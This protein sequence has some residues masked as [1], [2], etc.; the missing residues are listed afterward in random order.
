MNKNFLHR[1]K[2][3]DLNGKMSSLE[4]YGILGNLY[5]D[6]G[7]G[8]TTMLG[9]DPLELREPISGSID[10]TPETE[11]YQYGFGF[12]EGISLSKNHQVVFGKYNE[13]NELAIFLIGVGENKDTPKNAVELVKVSADEDVYQLN[14]R[15][16]KGMQT[17]ATEAYVAGQ[18]DELK[19]NAPE[20]LDTLEEIANLLTDDPNGELQDFITTLKN[21]IDAINAVKKDLK[22]E[23]SNRQQI[24]TKIN[25]TLDDL[26]SRLASLEKGDVG[27]EGTF[28][29]DTFL[30]E[31]EENSTKLYLKGQRQG[32]QVSK[33]IGMVN[34]VKNIVDGKCFKIYE[35]AEPVNNQT[36]IFFEPLDDGTLATTKLEE[37]AIGTKVSLKLGYHYINY[38]SVTSVN[39]GNWSITIDKAFER[40][41][42]DTSSN[43]ELHRLWFNDAPEI[44]D[45]NFSDFTT[46]AGTGFAGYA[47][48]LATVALADYSH[49]EGNKT[50]GG[51]RFS[52]A[53]GVDTQAGYASHS[54]GK[55]TRANGDQSHAEGYKTTAEGAEAHAEG[56]STLASGKNSHAEGNSTTASGENSHAEGEST[57]ASGK[58]SHAEG[59]NTKAFKD[60]S[61]AEGAH[62]NARGN[63]SHAEGYC[64]SA[65]GVEAHAEGCKSIAKGNYSHSEGDRSQAIGVASHAEGSYNFAEGDYSHAGGYNSKATK[66]QSFVHGAALQDSKNRQVIFG[67]FNKNSDAAFII[68]NGT[69]GDVRSNAFEVYEDGTIFAG[70]KSLSKKN[71]ELEKKIANLEVAAGIASKIQEE[72]VTQG[73]LQGDSDYAPYVEFSNIYTGSGQ[74]SVNTEDIKW[75][76]YLTIKTTVV[77]Y[78]TGASGI[79]YFSNA[80]ESTAKPFSKS[81]WDEG[82]SDLFF[83]LDDSEV[84]G[85]GASS[86]NRNC[87][88]EIKTQ[89]RDIW[90]PGLYRIS[91]PYKQ[92][93][94]GAEGSYEVSERIL[95]K[96][97]PRRM[98]TEWPFEG[99]AASIEYGYFS[100]LSISSANENVCSARYEEGF[101]PSQG[102]ITIPGSENWSKGE[103]VYFYIEKAN[104]Y[105]FDI[106]YPEKE[107]NEIE[108]KKNNNTIFN[109]SSSEKINMKMINDNVQDRILVDE[110]YLLKRVE[111]D[112][113]SNLLETKVSN[114]CLIY[115]K[116]LPFINNEG[117]LSLSLPGSGKGQIGAL[118]ADEDYGVVYYEKEVPE[119]INLNLPEIDSFS[120]TD[121][122]VLTF[123][124]ADL[125]YG[126]LRVKN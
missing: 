27:D 6:S 94:G 55:E 78:W 56:L 71:E 104:Y 88:F 47:E 46:E 111:K 81:L 124:P 54:E 90:T 60:Y 112:S 63:Y 76:R 50:V 1:I 99:Q 73:R 29:E 84:Y 18:I 125:N 31:D 116:A 33:G 53:E 108:V 65:E 41:P 119:Q 93:V 77:D 8:G 120:L 69:S 59:Y 58:N 14:I 102:S 38:A 61:H 95:S 5:A 126:I 11:P 82:N 22:D 91:A 87:F 115:S 23:T 67:C 37:L 89:N 25:A 98:N 26:D 75:E 52:H 83:A 100:L 66:N 51:G 107:F 68:G 122:E 16:G 101:S 64:S 10:Q 34:N 9:G 79:Y 86:G 118:S 17:I 35:I 106:T 48:G 28:D 30:V 15:N 44:G 96:F 4:D 97:I 24:D 13:D 32:Y 121:G 70:G 123:E 72:V 2:I 74:T 21:V 92:Q 42:S 36:T 40:A 12:G 113:I 39:P 45:R 19:G 114:N 117:T 49:A 62:T 43:P 105:P 3:I 85:E 7:T 110:S 103:I 109:F 20:M 57:T 80:D